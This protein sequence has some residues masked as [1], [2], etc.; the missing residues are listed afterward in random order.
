MGWQ[1]M[2]RLI[3]MLVL[4]G[5]FHEADGRIIMSDVTHSA[6][7]LHQRLAYWG[8]AI[9]GVA[10]TELEWGILRFFAAFREKLRAVEPTRDS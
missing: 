2:L 7:S 8:L 9:T 5:L 6:D 10:V 4:C 3:T 1:E